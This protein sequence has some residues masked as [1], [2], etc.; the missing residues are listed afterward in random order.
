M[1][2]FTVSFKPIEYGKVSS[3]RLVIQTSE[4]YWNFAVKGTFPKYVAPKIEDSRLDNWLDPNKK[5][6]GAKPPAQPKAQPQSKAAG[7]GKTK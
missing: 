4:Y 3:G 7:G 1:I 6:P 2:T 5:L